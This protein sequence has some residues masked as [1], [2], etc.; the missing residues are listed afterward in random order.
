MLHRLLL[1]RVQISKDGIFDHWLSGIEWKKKCGLN[2]VM[3]GGIID[4]VSRAA[5]IKPEAAESHP[6]GNASG[7]DDDQLPRALPTPRLSVD[8]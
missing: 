3:R 1:R 2:A 4:Q 8:T 7:L 6:A 5:K